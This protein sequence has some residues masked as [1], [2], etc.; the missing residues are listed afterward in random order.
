MKKKD[1]DKEEYESDVLDLLRKML[2]GIQLKDIDFDK[3]LKGQ[4]RINFLKYCDE[5]FSSDY[6]EM[7][8]SNIYYPSLLYA[9]QKSENY[10][11][12][13][14]NRATANG[15]ALVKE[16]FRSRS[17]QYQIEFVLPPDK[18]TEGKLFEPVGPP[19]L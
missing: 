7:I 11:E 4:E 5:V 1:F 15:T 14:F 19:K 13:T 10:D 12:V 8:I 9:A 17:Q 6:F 18:P 3:K 16:Y 2:N